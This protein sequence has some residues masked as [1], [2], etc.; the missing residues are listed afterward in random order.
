MIHACPD[1]SIVVPCYRAEKSLES[2]VAELDD[3]CDQHGWTHEIILV[4]DA[5]PDAT[6]VKIDEIARRNDHVIGVDLLS[7]HGQPMATMC[8]LSIARGRLIA[9]MDD[10]LEHRPDQLPVL[11]ARLDAHADL[12]AVVATWPIERGHFRDLGTRVH[13]FA[14]RVAWG[15]PKGFRH[16]AFRVMRRP[17]CDALVAY[18]TRSPVVGPMLTRLAGRVE[19][20]EVHNGERAHGHSGFTTRDGIR[21]VVLNFSS[22]STAPLKLMS[23]TGFILATFGF[24]AG[25][26]LLVRWIAG[27]DSPAGWLSVMLAVLVI[28]GANLMA[29]GVLGGYAEVIVREVRRSPRWSVRTIAGAVEEDES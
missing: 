2:L 9:T 3:V 6:W 20:V 18:E 22:G 26:A 16:T 19:N 13:S 12:D 5:S 17:V 4:N 8:G 7:N 15:T 27:A 25:A 21:R 23:L 29:M 11:I 24:L 28:G 14:D 10:D 1:L